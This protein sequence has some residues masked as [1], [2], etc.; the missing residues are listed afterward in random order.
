MFVVTGCETS[1]DL[2]REQLWQGL[3]RKAEDP[4]PFVRAITDCR[5]VERGHDWLV[6]EIVL[7]GERVRELVTFEAQNVVR[8]VRL[9][10]R[11][12]G[13]IENRI[14][15]ATDG[16]LALR[17]SFLL[18]AADI[19]AGSLEE[20]EYASTMRESY[21]A[22]IHSTLERTRALRDRRAS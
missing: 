14:E 18:E 5:V 6:R 22:A 20:R 12:A 8:F 4:V 7:R 13:T 19:A 9:S 16:A 3:I 17:F 2:T 1:S 11:V 21:L 10:G 15:A